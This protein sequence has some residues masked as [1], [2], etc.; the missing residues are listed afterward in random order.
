MLHLALKC[1]GI[2]YKTQKWLNSVQQHNTSR[3]GQV[4]NILYQVK[5]NWLYHDDDTC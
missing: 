2:G 1:P 3:V 5:Q 4:N